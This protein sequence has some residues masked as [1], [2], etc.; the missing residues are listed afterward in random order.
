MRKPVSY[1]KSPVYAFGGL[2]TG[3]DIDEMIT[4]WTMI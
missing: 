1:V 4:M 2:V 3:T